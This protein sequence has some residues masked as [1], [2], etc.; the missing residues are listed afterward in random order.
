[1]LERTW[2]LGV[3]RHERDALGRVIQYTP[4]DR[5][6]ADSPCQGWRV[7][8]V[9]AHLAASEVAA[10]AVLGGEPPSELDEYRKSLEG[11]PFTADGWNDWSVARRADT[12][13]LSLALEWGRAADLLLARASKVTDEDWRDRELPWTVDDV[14]TGYL[15][16]IRVAEWWVHGE[17]LLEGG[18]QPPR[19]EHRPIFCVNDLAIRLLPYS[20]D[21]DGLSFPGASVQVELEGVGEGTWHQGLEAGYEPPEGSR[22]D[23]VITGRG[24][25]FASVAGR[26]ADADVVLYEGMLQ[27]GGRVDICEA[28]LRS[29]RSFP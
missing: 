16:Q 5:W 4:P 29:L 26:R 13:H 6:E 19:L 14:R 27:I 25:A 23:A 11:E 7:K 1:M 10:A 12:P 21:R 20:L 17:D 2:L 3:A 24:Y 28:V 9:L 15:M 8:N 18:G 22:P